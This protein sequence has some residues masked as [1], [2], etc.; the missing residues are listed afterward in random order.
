MT[1]RVRSFGMVAIAVVALGAV[2]GG[3][4]ASIRPPGIKVTGYMLRAQLDSAQMVPAPAAAVPVGASGQFQ[5][6]LANAPVYSRPPGRSFKIVWR[7]A[8]RLTFSNLSGQVTKVQIGQGARGQAGPMLVALCGP[9]GTLTRGVVDV[10][11]AKAKV[12]LANGAFVTVSTT[13][14]SGGEI[15]GQIVKVRIVPAATVKP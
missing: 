1:K 9:C 13:T 10:T 8:W 7:L 4:A 6:L 3:V 14:N 2:A 11:A 15:R 12:L 5:A